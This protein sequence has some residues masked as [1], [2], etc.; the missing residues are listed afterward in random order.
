ME[1]TMGLENSHVVI[2]IIVS[3]QLPSMP[4]GFSFSFLTKVKQSPTSW[5]GTKLYEV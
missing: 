5:I 3:E 4:P 1:E 2:K